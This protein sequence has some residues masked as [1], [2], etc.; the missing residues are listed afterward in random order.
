MTE[1]DGA[2]SKAWVSYSNKTSPSSIDYSEDPDGKPSRRG[3]D[4]TVLTEQRSR[5]LKSFTPNY[6]NNTRRCRLILLKER[7]RLST[8]STRR[9]TPS[10]SR[11]QSSRHGELLRWFVFL[12][13]SHP[14]ENSF[15]LYIPHDL[16]SAVYASIS[17]L[18]HA[19][20]FCFLCVHSDSNTTHYA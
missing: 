13:R 10:L 9:K 16:V 7:S 14:R 17:N 11:R 2:T 4:E 8:T 1:V 20:V 6:V 12:S 5:R 18:Y 3:L 15:R 19:L